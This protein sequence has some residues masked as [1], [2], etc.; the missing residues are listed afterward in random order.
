[1]ADVRMFRFV[2]FCDATKAGRR[3]ALQEWEEA[4]P[5][6]HAHDFWKRIRETI[7][8]IERGKKPLSALELL[9]AQQTDKRKTTNFA[10][11]ARGYLGWRRNKVVEWFDPPKGTWNCGGLDVQVGADLGLKLDGVPHIIKL[12]FSDPRPSSI[13]IDAITHLL[14]AACAPQVGP[15][16]RSALLDVRRGV[17]AAIES[18]HPVVMRTLERQAHLWLQRRAS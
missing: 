5:Y 16:C 4:L 11:A 8:A 9:P 1:M 14:H 15:S 3:R 10:I 6:N 13:R 18:A 2:K 17:L 7:R 12:H